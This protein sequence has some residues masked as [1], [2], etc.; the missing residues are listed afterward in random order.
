[1][2]F[3]REGLADGGQSACGLGGQLGKGR[4]GKAPV[5]SFPATAIWDLIPTVSRSVPDDH[6]YSLG[7]IIGRWNETRHLRFVPELWFHNKSR[8]SCSCDRPLS[9]STKTCTTHVRSIQP[10][11]TTLAKLVWS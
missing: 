11:N 9:D 10:R 2:F 1:M 6:I 3:A 7:C 4:E 5:L 8:D